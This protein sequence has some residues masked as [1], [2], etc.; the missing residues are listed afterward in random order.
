MWTQQLH[1]KR[2]YLSTKLDGVTF[3]NTVNVTETN[4]P[5]EWGSDPQAQRTNLENTLMRVAGF[6]CGKFALGERDST[7]FGCD[8]T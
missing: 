7:V 2:F 4:F 8:I 1:P 3:Q 6:S 5:C